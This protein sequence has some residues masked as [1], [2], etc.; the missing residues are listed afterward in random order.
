MQH[1]VCYKS[2]HEKLL[3][4]SNYL[5]SI[6]EIL[7]FGY[8]KMYVCLLWWNRHLDLHGFFLVKGYNRVIGDTEGQEYYKYKSTYL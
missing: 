2:Q 5:F 7:S 4:L 3:Y 6:E 1:T 8:K